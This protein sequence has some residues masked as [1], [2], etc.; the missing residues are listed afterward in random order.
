[1]QKIDFFSACQHHHHHVMANVK[2][3]SDWLPPQARLYGMKERESGICVST[4]IGCD[5]WKRCWVHSQGSNS[6]VV[7]FR[8]PPGECSWL[9]VQ[10]AYIYLYTRQKCPIQIDIQRVLDRKLT[11]LSAPPNS[12]HTLRH[13]INKRSWAICC[14]WHVF[15]TLAFQLQFKLSTFFSL[16]RVCC[17]QHNFDSISNEKRGKKSIS[18][19][20]LCDCAMHECVASRRWSCHSPFAFPFPILRD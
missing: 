18:I 16:H 15:Y 8:K 5:V 11:Q 6:F 20:V 4:L 10:S 3:S 2:I 12:P 9:K 1:M 13:S 7:H 17:S 14:R 19:P